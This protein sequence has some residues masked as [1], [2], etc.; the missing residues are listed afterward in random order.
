VKMSGSL[1][2]LAALERAGLLTKDETAGLAAVCAR[3]PVGVTAP[4]AALIDPADPADP[5]R[6]QFVP[7]LREADILPDEL[8]DPI[9]DN[10][11]APVKGIVHRY[12]D[13][14]LFNPTTSCAAYCRFCFRRAAVGRGAGMLSPAETAT[15]INYIRAHPEIREVIFSGGDPLTLSD[16]KLAALIAELNAIDHVALLRFHTRVPVV[17]PA[18][19]KAGLLRALQGRAPVYLLLHCNHP[20]ELTAEARAALARLSRAGVT[21]LSQSVLL[22]GVNDDSE[23]L[24]ALMRAFLACR[25]VP[26]YLH[27]PDL[28]QGTAHFRLPLARGLAL[29]QDL[30]ARLSGLCQVH[31][32]LE[33]PGGGGKMPLSPPYATPND[34]GTW[35]LQSPDGRVVTYQDPALPAGA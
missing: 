12:A 14:V 28:A 20:R 13:R 9:G 16:K 4:L 19:I 3:L 30:R 24:E 26:H 31:Y 10:A 22:A 27:H 32:M 11:H 25:V 33:I 18:R 29:M 5:V 1:K 23:T 34:D 6:A 21:L 7:S 17:D 15:A 8:V 35:R 2:T